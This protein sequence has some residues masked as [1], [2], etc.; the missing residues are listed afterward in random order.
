MVTHEYQ[1]RLHDT[2]AAGVI[3]FASLLR[4]AHEVF[5]RFMSDAGLEI[6][7]LLDTVPYLLPIVHAEADFKA[8]IKLGMRLQVQ[9]SVKRLGTSSFTTRY[10]FAGADG[11]LMGGAE[12]VHAAI[13][14]PGGL[15][16]DLPGPLVQALTPHLAE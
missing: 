8:P 3:Y 2:D 13:A 16:T 14:R 11:R 5:E 9:F 10:V 6:G 4:I 15:K 12:I 1:V 7:Q